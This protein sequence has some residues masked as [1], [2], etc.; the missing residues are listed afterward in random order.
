V[1]VFN[2][3]EYDLLFLFA[4]T[5]TYGNIVWTKTRWVSALAQYQKSLPSNLSVPKGGLRVEIIDGG[6]DDQKHLAIPYLT[7]TDN[8][9]GDGRYI[10]A[11]EFWTLDAKAGSSNSG[12]TKSIEALAPGDASD[13]VVIRTR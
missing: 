2:F 3:T 13:T 12:L 9:T 10:A 6:P 4:V 8:K 1:G 7:V 5:D 11:S